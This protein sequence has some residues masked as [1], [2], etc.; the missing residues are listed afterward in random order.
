MKKYLTVGAIISGICFSLSIVS[1]TSIAVPVTTSIVGDEA[2]DQ[3]SEGCTDL[4]YN[5]TYKKS[6][7]S[8]TNGEVS[9]LQYFLQDQGFLTAEPN[10]VFGPSTL[11]AVK[12]FQKKNGFITS[13]YVGPVTRAK[14]REISCRSASSVN[15]KTVSVDVPSTKTP[16][17]NNP[18]ETI[19][20]CNGAV[21]YEPCRTN[22]SE[23]L[24]FVSVKTTGANYTNNSALIAGYVEPNNG[25]LKPKAWFEWGTSMYGQLN[26]TPCS[27]IYD[28][29]TVVS[30]ST[31]IYKLAPNTTY[32]YRIVASGSKGNVKGEFLSFTTESALSSSNTIYPVI[33]FVGAP[34]IKLSYDLNNKETELVG[35]AKVK[36]TA[37]NSDI[38]VY[39]V[40]GVATNLGG[41]VNNEN[42]RINSNGVKY[43]GSVSSFI[44]DYNYSNDTN[45]IIK[46]NDTATIYIRNTIPTKELFA[47]AYSFRPSNLSYVDINTNTQKVVDVSSYVNYAKSNSVIIIGETSPYISKATDVSGYI[48]ISGARLNLDGNYLQIDGMGNSMVSK[49]NPTDSIISIKKSDFALTRN[50][51][52][53]FH[54]INIT[55]S[56]TGNSNNYGLNVQQE[57]TTIPTTQLGSYKG[58]LGGSAAPFI[59]TE[60]VSKEYAYTNCVTNSYNNPTKS[61]RCTWEMEEIYS[62]IPPASAPAPTMAT[63]PSPNQT[64]TTIT[65][66][67]QATA[68][69]SAMNTSSVSIANPTLVSS[70]PVSQF[71]VGGS[72]FGIATFK[73]RTSEF[74]T[75]A[76][77]RELRF[78][79]TG[80]DAVTSVTVGGVTAPV[81]NGNVTATGLSLPVSSTGVD[82]PVTVKFSGFQNSTSGGSLTSGVSNVKLTLNYIEVTNANGSVIINNTPVSS[83]IMTLV[84]S[85]P[86]VTLSNGG[87][88]LVLGS[89]NKIGEFTVSADVNGK[90]GFTSTIL[91]VSSIGINGFKISSPRVANG[92]TTIAGLSATVLESYILI[93]SSSPFEIPAGTS[94]TFS[95]FAT[96]SG[97]IQTGLTPKLIS[98]LALPASFKWND[99]IGGNIQHHGALIYNFPINSFIVN[100]S[101]VTTPTPVVT[102]TTARLTCGLFRGGTNTATNMIASPNPATSV[103]DTDSACISYCD[104]SGPK[105]ADM[106]LRGTGTIKTYTL[107]PTPTVVAPAVLKIPTITMTVNPT[108]VPLNGSTTL[109]WSSTNVDYCDFSH[110][111]QYGPVTRATSGTLTIKPVTNSIY[112]GMKCGGVNG[113]TS[114]QV[115]VKV[116]T[117]SSSSNGN[118]KVLGAS[119]ACI[120]IS[121]NLHRGAESSAVTTLQKFLQSKGLLNEV[122][123]FYGDKTIEAVKGYQATIGLAPTGMVYEV[124]RQAMRDETCQ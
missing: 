37:G 4:S 68:A 106:C 96:V 75:S 82:V 30:C 116:V 89:E 23:T 20:N 27:Y 111:G 46:A 117:L 74:N 6:K 2:P 42:V 3:A 71:V 70:S 15:T 54:T 49:F 50:L 102:N 62:N 63:S 84:A 78:S 69:V 115:L 107:T 40:Y 48:T 67:S 13:G 114:T 99:F 25:T 33:E 41:F 11:K 81:V 61:I 123:G 66:S 110:A 64:P 92:N 101:V 12:Y 94:I 52:S 113:S 24:S 39:G 85:K 103:A 31:N 17:V 98:S 21:S 88:S 36:I 16:N 121:R 35:V 7:D 58:Y 57:I 100:G 9:D 44:S 47:G 87:G 120:Y 34:S 26:A 18:V 28:G 43:R 8:N 10:G 72:T 122:S 108:Q 124:T 93:T 90:I 86:T 55:N 104:A 97:T 32:Y 118:A 83:N 95:V 80:N 5:L 65:N 76:T 38:D 105:N 56:R 22:T 1:A 77:V 60:N 53:G 91:N 45:L 19:Y 51:S 119:T 59:S 109:R 112:Y 73:L 29:N 14:I 79:T